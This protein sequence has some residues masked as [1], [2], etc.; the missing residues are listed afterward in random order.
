MQL[1][2]LTRLSRFTTY[3]KWQV[4]D[5]PLNWIIMRKN[6]FLE[7]FF[8]RT[9]C[10]CFRD[11][12][13]LEISDGNLTNWLTHLCD[14]VTIARIAAKFNHARLIRYLLINKLIIAA[15]YL[16]QIFKL[17]HNYDYISSITSLCVCIALNINYV[18]DACC[19]TI[20]IVHVNNYYH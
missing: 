14:V 11:K 18:I 17:W 10:R 6:R 13:M 7:Y 20:H 19:S 15:I 16:H 9:F 2:P 4:Q 8:N 5:A 1:F 12:R 3:D